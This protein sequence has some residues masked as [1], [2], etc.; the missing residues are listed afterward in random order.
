MGQLL[1]GVILFVAGILAGLYVGFWWALVGG[2]ILFIEGVQADPINAAWL[3]YGILR[4]MFAGLLG[5]VTAIAAIIP[6]VLLMAI[7]L[8]KL[9]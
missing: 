4:V 2:L 3:A 8:D 5:Y 7:G 6:S 1:I 9:K